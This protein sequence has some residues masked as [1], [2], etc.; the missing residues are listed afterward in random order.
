MGC[1]FIRCKVPHQTIVTHFLAPAVEE[2]DGR[3]ADDAE[4]FHQCLV[5]II[6]RRDVSLQELQLAQQGLNA[7]YI[8]GS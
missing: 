2:Q 6:I 5:R 8:S 7:V 3:R 1:E 4:G